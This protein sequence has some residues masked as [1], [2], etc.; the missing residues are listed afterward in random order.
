MALI[1]CPECAA[2]ISSMANKCPKCGFPI[3]KAEEIAVTTEAENTIENEVEN[4]ADIPIVNTDVFEKIEERIAKKKKINRLILTLAISIGAALLIAAAV[5]TI[6]LLNKPEK[7]SYDGFSFKVPHSL[8]KAECLVDGAD[9]QYRFYN[10]VIFVT[11]SYLEFDPLAYYN[12]MDEVLT[13]LGENFDNMFID[14][15]VNDI[16]SQG[17]ISYYLTSINNNRAL[18]VTCPYVDKYDL[19]NRYVRYTFV[20]NKYNYSFIIVGL[21]EVE[22]ASKSYL[23]EYNKLVNS[24]KISDVV[25]GI[26]YYESGAKPTIGIAGTG[27]TSVDTSLKEVLDEYEA[28]VDTYVDFMEK[29]NADS[30]DLTMLSD[31]FIMLEQMATL[32]EKVENLDEDSLTGA[33]YVYYI[34]VMTRCNDKLMSVG[35]Y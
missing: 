28:F 3:S 35:V 7:K 8:S 4:R 26:D 15:G 25:S 29:Y 33:D 14:L 12:S 34:E 30:T 21:D 1:D 20:Y 13:Y 10:E 18:V 9:L 6:V 11:Y 5:V 16:Q 27:S 32:A 24:I 31:Y 17:E 23:K 22:N 2:R 19:E